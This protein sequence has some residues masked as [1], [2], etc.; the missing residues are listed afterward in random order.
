MNVIIVNDF[1]Y[2]DGGASRIAVDTAKMMATY[3]H[4]VIFFQQSVLYRMN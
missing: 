1:A 4:N 3:G 2:V